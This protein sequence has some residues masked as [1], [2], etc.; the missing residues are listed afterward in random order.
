[1]Y[2][3]HMQQLVGLYKRIW[4]F[5][6][7]TMPTIKLCNCK[8][9]ILSRMHVIAHVSVHSSKEQVLQKAEEQKRKISSLLNNTKFYYNFSVQRATQYICLKVFSIF[10]NWHT[11]IVQTYSGN[12][13]LLSF[14]LA[15][16]KSRLRVQSQHAREP[17]F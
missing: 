14:P 10:H 11:Y 1:M 9:F 4:G 5:D 2:V 12:G 7:C 13:A 8:S 3:I 17:Q 15:I 16:A 6:G